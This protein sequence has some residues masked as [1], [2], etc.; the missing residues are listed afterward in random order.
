MG[1]LIQAELGVIMFICDTCAFGSESSHCKRNLFKMMCNPDYYARL[2]TSWLPVKLDWMGHI[3]PAFT[4]A[5]L[6]G[7]LPISLLGAKSSLH[8]PRS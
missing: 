3:K 8:N 7:T 2:L 4:A 1:C 6:M 5:I